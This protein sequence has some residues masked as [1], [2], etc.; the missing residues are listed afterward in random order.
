MRCRVFKSVVSH[1]SPSLSI[2]RVKT[3]LQDFMNDTIGSNGGE[4]LG[5]FSFGTYATQLAEDLTTSIVIDVAVSID[6]AFGLDLSNLFNSSLSALERIPSPFMLINEFNINGLLGINEWSSKLEFG[7]FDF[8]IT[9]AKALVAVSANVASS[10]IPIQSPSD[11]LSLFSSSAIEFSASLDVSFPVFVIVGDFGFGARIDYTD[12]DLLDTSTST[13]TFTKDALVKID[14]I[15]S[16][17][18]KL[19]DVTI[20]I[21]TFEPFTTQIPLIKESI[22]SIIAGDG[23]VSDFFDLR[24]WV[25]GLEGMQIGSEAVS[26]VLGPWLE[27]FIVMSFDILLTFD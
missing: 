24:E 21:D 2:C 13:P 5:G 7:E 1:T 8:M 20:F 27:L 23:L 25:N 22:N 6:I 19:R 17:V 18:D 12:S 3:L 16:A 11:F 10:P 14:L 9:E 26:K 4:E 15:K